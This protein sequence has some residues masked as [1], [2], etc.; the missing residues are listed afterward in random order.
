MARIRREPFDRSREFEVCRTIKVNGRLYEPGYL[1]DKTEVNV[2]RLRQM[3][4]QRTLNMLPAGVVKTPK[5]V[6]GTSLKPDF[7]RL[8][9]EALR[10]WLSSRH[11]IPRFN[12]KKS[13]LALMASEEWD[14]MHGA[15]TEEPAQKAA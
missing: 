5:M 4:E 2:R 8:P 14:R 12:T 15:P 7:A 13:K 6:G 1:F 11:I 3:F 9:I 10:E